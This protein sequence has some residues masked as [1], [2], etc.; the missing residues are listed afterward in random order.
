MSKKDR[1]EKRN[2]NAQKVV[3]VMLT[4]WSDFA[5]LLFPG[6]FILIAYGG[7]D[8]ADTKNAATIENKSFSMIFAVV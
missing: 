2:N 3:T 1:K 7:A 4:D 8:L 5:L 6:I